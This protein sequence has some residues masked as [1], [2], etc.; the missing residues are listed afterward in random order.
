MSDSL[1]ARAH[2]DFESARRKSFWR[3]IAAWLTG[4]S[5]ALL[6]YSE[7]RKQLPLGGQR[8]IGLRTVPLDHIIGSVGRYRDFDRAFLPKHTYTIKRWVNI[9]R[10][11]LQD[12]ILP[13]I[14]LYKIGEAYFVKDGNHRVSVAR[15]RGQIDI[16]AYVIELDVPVEIGPDTNIDD[17]IRKKEEAHFVLKTGIKELRPDSRI[18]LT[19]PGGYDKLLEHI[20][21]HH[22]FMGIEHQASVPWQKAVKSW[23]DEVYLPLLKVIYD[24]NILHKF[25]GR[26]EADLYLWIIEHLFYLREQYAD[27]TLE[28][29]VEHFVENYTEDPFK[30][31]FQ[32]IRN[33]AHAI[34]AS[35]EEDLPTNYDIPPNVF[36]QP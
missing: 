13:P 19:L 27:I 14:E 17:L 11:H 31:L 23:Y 22:W 6:P 15:E 36:H 7:V 2:S 9:D 1:N 3:A 10:A 4:A 16:D 35:E 20:H 26:T 8:D 24:S 30:R 25:P 18:E 33:A 34:I 32:I 28:E 29:A 5:N 12:I 21:V